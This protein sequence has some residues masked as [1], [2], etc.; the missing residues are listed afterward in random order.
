[1]YLMWIYCYILTY[2]PVITM[3][4]NN[5]VEATERMEPL[6]TIIQL[7]STLLTAVEVVCN[8]SS[9][10]TFKIG[11]HTVTCNAA[12]NSASATFSVTITDTIAP[13][14]IVPSDMVLEAASKFGAAAEF[15]TTATDIVDG[16]RVVT[17]N[18][19]SSSTFSLGTTSVTCSAIDA[20]SS[21]ATG[22]FAAIVKDTTA[23]A[24]TVPDS[25]VVEATFSVGAVSTFTTSDEQSI[26][27][28]QSLD[29]KNITLYLIKIF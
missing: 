13:K 29:M 3:P 6:F 1:M 22:S 15:I 8:P 19:P 28:S 20:T 23:P 5:V 4:E 10:S 25:V 7:Q 24:L 26:G 16:D 11:V 2:A 9:A 18:P 12:G 14:L 17:C 27:D 21:I